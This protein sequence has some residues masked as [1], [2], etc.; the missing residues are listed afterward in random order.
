[1]CTGG[2]KNKRENIYGGGG[3]VPAGNWRVITYAK[4]YF[5]MSLSKRWK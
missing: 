5:K 1:M 2:E 3:K 4:A